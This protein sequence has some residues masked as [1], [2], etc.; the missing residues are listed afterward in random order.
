MMIELLAPAKVNLSLYI[1]DKRDDGYHE[2]ITRMQ[3]LDLCDRLTIELT[4][5]GV[6]E[7]CCDAVD[8]LSDETNLAVRAAKEFFNCHGNERGY[9]LNIELTKRIPVAAGLGGGSSDGAAILKGLNRLFGAPF[10]ELELIS[11][12]RR[13]GA[14][15]GFFVSDYTSVCATGIGDE[16]EP[17]ED[18]GGHYYLLVNPGISV[19]TKWVYDN[20]RLTKKNNKFRFCGS[21]NIEK[22]GFSIDN[23]YND[24][25]QVTIPRHPVIGELKKMLIKQGAAG[26]LM[27]GSGPTVFGLFEDKNC[28]EAA[29]DSLTKRFSQQK[30][31]RIISTEAFSRI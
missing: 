25:E 2:L 26:A 8:V 24:L 30:G 27:S 9:G 3:K 29:F 28:I 15:F 14:D 10:S 21:Q 17:A 23:L 7:I 19:E 31:Y 6:V 16:L 12:G 11:V 4:D 1:T 20:Y 22:K 18:V 5:S 13:L